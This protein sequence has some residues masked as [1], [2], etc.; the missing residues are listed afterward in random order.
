MVEQIKLRLFLT[1]FLLIGL[2]AIPF[3]MLWILAAIIFEP[4]SSRAINILVSY[5]RVAN[6]MT[7]G[8]GHE[9]ISSR[10]GRMQLSGYP[11]PIWAKVLGGLL[12]KLQSDHCK[13]SVGV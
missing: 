7:G 13:D 6:T 3:S 12:D 1:V 11:L 8:N 2:M 5:D 10:I 4:T 9:T